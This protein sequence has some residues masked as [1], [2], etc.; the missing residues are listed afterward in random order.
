MFSALEYSLF[1]IK[2]TEFIELA[3]IISIHIISLYDCFIVVESSFF[4]KG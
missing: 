4:S 1:S 3:K 2:I